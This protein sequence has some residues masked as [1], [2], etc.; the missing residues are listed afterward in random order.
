MGS[1]LGVGRWRV[2]YSPSPPPFS[3]QSA[4]FAEKEGDRRRSCTANAE[5]FGARVRKLLKTRVGR[6][7]GTEDCRTEGPGGGVAQ[8]PQRRIAGRVY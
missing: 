8:Q 6:L 5:F 3:A 7:Y 2:G 1:D 4:Q